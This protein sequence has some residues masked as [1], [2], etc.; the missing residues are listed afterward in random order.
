MTDNILR[1]REKNQTTNKSAAQLGF[2]RS[3]SAFNPYARLKF[4]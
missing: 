3:Y 2:R 1:K 4:P